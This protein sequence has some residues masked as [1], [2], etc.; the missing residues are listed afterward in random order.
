MTEPVSPGLALNPFD[1]LGP[2]HLALLPEQPHISLGRL[3]T[4]LLGLS[5]YRVPV[6]LQIFIGLRRPL[7]FEESASARGKGIRFPARHRVLYIVSRQT[8]FASTWW[9]L[10]RRSHQIVASTT[11]LVVL[12]RSGVMPSAEFFRAARL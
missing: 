9:R 5:P 12:V 7:V 4:T 6:C 8:A 2:C 3:G 11:L 1:D 10:S